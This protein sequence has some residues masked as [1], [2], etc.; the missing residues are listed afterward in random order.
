[1]LWI[2]E[3]SV[4]SGGSREGAPA[5]SQ[6]DTSACNRLGHVGQDNKCY[7]DDCPNGCVVRNGQVT[8]PTGTVLGVSASDCSLAQNKGNIC[9]V[10]GTSGY[11]DIDTGTA[12]RYCKV[13]SGGG[14]DYPTT[15][16]NLTS[17]V[18]GADE[19][20]YDENYDYESQEGAPCRKGSNGYGVCRLV[21]TSKCI[22]MCAGVYA[23]Q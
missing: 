7:T 23:C 16:G 11:C 8:L 18:S 4:G 12:E 21:A 22:T 1:M 20:T 17:C 5:L 13:S 10:G 6:T 14:D 15:P 2:R 9:S 3:K 19:S